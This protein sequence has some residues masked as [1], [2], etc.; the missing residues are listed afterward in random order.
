MEKVSFILT[1]YNS[2]DN[3]KETID[4][5]LQQDYTEIEIIVKDGGSS[6]GTVELI[7]A[8]KEKLKERLIWVSEEDAGI[9]DAMNQGYRLSSGDIIVFFNDILQGSHAV[10]DMV[11]AIREQGES[12][13]GAHA[14]LVYAD[15]DGK[16]VRTW[17]MGKG[18]FTRGWMPGHPTLYVKRSVYEKYGVYDTSYRCAADYEFMVRAF[19]GKEERLAYVPETIVRMIYGGTSTGGL[20]NYLVSLK[21]GHNALKKNHIRGAMWIDIQ[22]TLRVLGQFGS[23]ESI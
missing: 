23:R 5:I 14:D 12:C 22:R 9:Y 10:S 18:K 3:F 21:E 4:S 20:K 15:A 7:Q 17:K 8:Y 1:T 19:W 13:M 6:D 11:K 16:V 2:L